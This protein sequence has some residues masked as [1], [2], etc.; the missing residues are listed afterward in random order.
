[1]VNHT[2]KAFNKAIYYLIFEDIYVSSEF[3]LHISDSFPFH[4]HK[5]FLKSCYIFAFSKDAFVSSM[6]S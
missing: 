1:M 4:Y 5:L 6:T 3:N 2:Q